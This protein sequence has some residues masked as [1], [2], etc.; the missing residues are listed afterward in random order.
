MSSFCYLFIP[1]ETDTQVSLSNLS[2]D[3]DYTV[4]WVI[5]EA[6]DE[7]KLFQG[8]LSDAALVL[9]QYKV[10]VVLPGENVAFFLVSIPGTNLQKIRLALPYALEDSVIDDVDTLHFSLGREAADNQYQV[11]VIN[12]KY[13]D[14][15]LYELL[16]AGVIPEII[17]ADYS[18]LTEKNT[19]FIGQNKILYN[20]NDIQF[21]S[22]PDFISSQ[23]NDFLTNNNIFKII[24]CKTTQESENEK[25]EID[26]LAERL[27]IE[28]E[29]CHAQELSCL[30]KHGSADNVIN[31]LQGDY[32]KKK[33]WSQERK[34][35][36][37]IAIM[38]LIWIGIK[39]SLFAVDYIKLNQQ[40]KKINAEIV[41]LYKKTF[42]KSK[43]I[44][45]AKS[46]MQQKLNDLKKRKG[47]KGR[48]FS[49]ML[50]GSAAVLGKYKN[51]QIKALRYFD[52]RINLE[53]QLSSLQELDK[54]KEQLKKEKG[55]QVDIQNA[56]SEKGFVTARLQ[57]TGVVL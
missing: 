42:P 41:Q 1:K 16:N 57:I 21:S 15:I 36:M 7:L 50:S 28:I 18:I 19:L 48:G 49:E 8:S 37:P 46:Q 9:K 22:N 2:E 34:T 6:N 53:L 45:D 54:L 26:E 55:Y 24:Q 38:F 14:W 10:I 47:L 29:I 33:N 56:S 11:T 17:T 25:T 39:G 51:L 27:E 4:S 12:K 52:G 43:R 3:S 23:N 13:L 40:S 35:W 31:L 20:G 5:R 44:I 30:I 32:K